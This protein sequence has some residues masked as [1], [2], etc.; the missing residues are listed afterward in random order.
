MIVTSVPV[1]TSG[2]GRMML[3]P[4]TGTITPF[5]YMLRWMVPIVFLLIEA[6]VIGSAASS[7][8][9]INP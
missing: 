2:G 9:H 4:D 7:S 6:I 3:F 8:A 5:P 1:R